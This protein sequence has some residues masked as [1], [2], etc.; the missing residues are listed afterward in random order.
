MY[1]LEFLLSIVPQFWAEISEELPYIESLADPQFSELPVDSRPLAALLCSKVFFYLGERDEAVEFALRAA[2][3]FEKEPYAEF[4]ETI[5][6][7]CIDRAITDT[8]KGQT[9]DPRLEEIVEGVIRQGS[10]E[11]AKLVSI[12]NIVS[13]SRHSVLRCLFAA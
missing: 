3:A 10:S 13:D 4:K 8:E 5:I 2:A 6:A 1:A 7:G 12:P 9:V 11:G